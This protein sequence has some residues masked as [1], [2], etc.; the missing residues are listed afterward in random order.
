MRTEGEGHLTSI[1]AGSSENPIVSSAVKCFTVAPSARRAAPAERLVRQWHRL[2]SNV[3]G[4][5]GRRRQGIA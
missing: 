2:P 4:R 5:G 1:E 3:L